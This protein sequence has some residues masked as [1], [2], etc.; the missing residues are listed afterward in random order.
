MTRIPKFEAHVDDEGRLV[1]P[2]EMISHFGLKPGVQVGI[3]DGENYLCLQR[4]ITHLAKVYIEPTNACNLEC[5]TCI[6]NVWDEPIGRMSTKTFDRI[7]EGLKVF[8]PKPTVFFG[9]FGEPLS[10]PGIVD[11]VAQ[12]KALGITVELI[13]N[14]TLLTR[15]MSRQLIEAGLDML[16]VS[17]D[18]A[19]PE[20]YADVRLGAALPEVLANLRDFSDARIGSSYYHF[21]PDPSIRPQIGMVFVAMKRNIADLPS[22]VRLGNRVG[23]TRFL[24]TNV[25]PYTVDMCNEVLYLRALSDLAYAPSSYRMELPKI[26]I[27]KDTAEP[28]FWTMRSG[29]SLSL[30]GANL[31]D[32]KDRCPF[33]EEG[34]TAIAWDGSLTPCLPL[35]HNHTS[36]MN[37][38][39][40]FSKRHVIGNVIERELKELWNDRE[41]TALRDRVQQFDFSPCTFCGGCDLSEKNEEDC[42]G[43]PFPT[44]GGCLWAQGIIQCP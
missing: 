29:H 43:S 40:R 31:D 27:D 17:L 41:Y 38:Q 15:E 39:E 26:N 21:P 14:G 5:R 7:M 28:L 42:F 4:P 24:V 16:W 10:H 44:C 9:G 22:V 33:I 18:G 6:R 11:M 13:T 20:S 25:L 34:A 35:V 3:D 8:S 12:V 1:L 19:T 37:G 36:F 32:A 2:R 30:A 23:A